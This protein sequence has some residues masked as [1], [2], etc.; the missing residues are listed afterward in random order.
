MHS[1]VAKRLAV[2]V[3]NASLRISHESFNDISAEKLDRTFR[4]SVFA[5]FYLCKAVFRTSFQAYNTEFA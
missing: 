1:A 3:N 5:S 4:T 2:L